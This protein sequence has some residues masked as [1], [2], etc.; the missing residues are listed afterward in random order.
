MILFASAIATLEGLLGC[1]P[2]EQDYAFYNPQKDVLLYAEGGFLESYTSVELYG[3]STDLLIF[4]Q[5]DLPEITD[6]VLV[7]TISLRTAY[8]GH[9]LEM[10]A[11]LQRAKMS[12]MGHQMQF[13]SADTVRR[14]NAHGGSDY[15]LIFECRACVQQWFSDSTSIRP[16]EIEIDSVFRVNNQYIAIEKILG[17]DRRVPVQ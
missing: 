4:V 14:K 15:Q 13:V 6:S 3:D 9:V 12:I 16:V 7:L 2:G 5:G 10:A 17:E 8:I 1:I 11:E